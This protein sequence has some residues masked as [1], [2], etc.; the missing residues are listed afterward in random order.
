MADQPGHVAARRRRG[1]A[2]A[3]DARRRAQR[4]HHRHR[5]RPAPARRMDLGAFGSRRGADHPGEPAVVRGAGRCLRA[6]ALRRRRRSHPVGHRPGPADPA[7]DRRAAKP[8]PHRRHPAA[9]PAAAGTALPLQHRAGQRRHGRHV[10][11]AIGFHPHRP[12][13]R[14]PAARGGAHRRPPASPPGGPVLRPVRRTG[15]DHP[16]RP[17]RRVALRRARRYGRGRCRRPDRAAVRR[18]TR[19]GGRSGRPAGIP[20]RAGAHRRRPA[21]VRADQPP[22]PARRLVAADPAARDLRRLLRAAAARRRLLPGLP[23]LAGRA[24]PRR[25]PPGLGRGA[26]RFRHAHPGRPGGP[27]GAGPPRLR[28]VLCP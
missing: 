27:V 6:R 10:R 9:D 25:R 17:R 22:H 24:R 13:R 19:R 26:V 18:R 11:G 2:H 12:P 7:A 20:H 16:R 23:H 8:A 3:A 1:G 21:P 5:R 15:A 28:K 4:R 14:R